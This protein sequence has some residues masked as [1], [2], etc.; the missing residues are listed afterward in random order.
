MNNYDEFQKITK[1]I[2]MGGGCLD[3]NKLK[4]SRLAPIFAQMARTYQNPLYH[5]EIDV[6]SHT[7]MVCEEI[8]KQPEYKNGSEKEKTI[9]FWAALLHDIG[10]TVCTVECDGVLKSPN[11][12][13]KG[14]VMARA[15]LW[16]DF[17]LCGSFEKQQMRE[18]ICTLIRYHSFPP[19]A[20]SYENADFRLLKIAANGELASGFSV[21]KLCALERADALG[22]IHSGA[23]DTLDK[24]EYCKLL[25]SD[26]ECLEKPYKFADAFSARA[27]FRGKTAWKEHNMINDSWGTIILM[28]GL[29]GTGKDTYIKENYPHL[30]MISLDDIRKELYISPTEKQ[31]R[32]IAAALERAREYLRK[33]Q[34]FVWN[35][36]NITTQIRDMQIS[37]FEDYGASAEIVFLE[38]EWEE[39]I[40][41]NRNRDAEV[42]LHAIE[43]MLA[44][45]VL[46]ERYESEKVTWK[47]V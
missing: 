9:L 42:P 15:L 25:A 24:I 5:G 44:R 2:P 3:W 23:D 36:T 17:G 18:A 28:S 41:R 34:P 40:N 29:P 46:P 27:Y 37:L 16:K 30:P 8:I 43:N 35:A 33:K 13:A 21:E 1:L 12:S 6:L 20:L 39:E 14:A 22:R 45:L 38:T 10:K 47:I 26:L 31:G 7:K 19:Y 32:V 4:A 11:H